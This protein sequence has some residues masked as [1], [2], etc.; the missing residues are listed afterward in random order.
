MMHDTYG[1][2]AHFYTDLIDFTA[3]DWDELRDAMEDEEE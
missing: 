1:T 3:I 2:N